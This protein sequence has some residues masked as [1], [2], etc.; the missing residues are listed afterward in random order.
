M[1]FIDSD[2]TPGIIYQPGWANVKLKETNARR[3]NNKNLI[4]TSIDISLDNIIY[5]L[6]EYGAAQEKI[7]FILSSYGYLFSSSDR[8]YN[9]LIFLDKKPPSMITVGGTD[10]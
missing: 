8:T 3:R 2:V 7:H 1:S 5:F 10:K 9:W 6:L 4:N